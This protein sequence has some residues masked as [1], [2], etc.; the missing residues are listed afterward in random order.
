MDP[1]L[2]R[3]AFSVSRYKQQTFSM[4]TGDYISGRAEKNAFND[5]PDLSSERA[6]HMVRTVTFLQKKKKSGD[7][8]TD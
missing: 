3:N 6:P 1:D 8:P 5:R 7:R 4:F 2:V